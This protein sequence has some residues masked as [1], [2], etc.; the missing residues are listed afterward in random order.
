VVIGLTFSNPPADVGYALTLLA[1]LVV[2]SKF[3][4]FNKSIGQADKATNSQTSPMLD[5]SHNYY[6]GSTF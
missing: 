4:F 1:G 2:P 5:V 3:P 6:A